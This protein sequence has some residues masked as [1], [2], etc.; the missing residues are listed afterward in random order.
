MELR[1]LQELHPPSFEP[2]ERQ[3]QPWL[4]PHKSVEQRQLRLREPLQEGRDQLEHQRVPPPLFGVPQLATLPPQQDQ[5]A[6]VLAPRR[7]QQWPRVRLDAPRQE[8]LEPVHRPLLT[9]WAEELARQE[10]PVPE[11][12]RHL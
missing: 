5:L 7:L 11:L 9:P 3:L 2:P 6:T 12:H 4:H 1:Q 10:Q 8:P